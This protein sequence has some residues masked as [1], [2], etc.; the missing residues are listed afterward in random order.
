M[1]ESGLLTHWTQEWTP[2]SLNCTGLKPVTNAKVVNMIDFQGALYVLGGGI[3]VGIL[4]LVTE[5]IIWFIQRI[6]HHYDSRQT[7][8]LPQYS[9]DNGLGEEFKRNIFPRNSSN[10]IQSTLEE[11]QLENNDHEA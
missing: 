3:I 11:E 7:D 6:K 8:R 5:V 2:R 10:S 4:V 1:R 9:H